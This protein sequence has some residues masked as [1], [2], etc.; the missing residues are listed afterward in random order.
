MAATSVARD[1]IAA[2]KITGRL[3]NLF[4]YVPSVKRWVSSL[5]EYY[6]VNGKV[7]SSSTVELKD[8]HAGGG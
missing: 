6:D 2:K 3:Y 4:Y 1:V 8:F 5:E 7:T